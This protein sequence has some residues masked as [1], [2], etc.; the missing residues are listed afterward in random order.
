MPAKPRGDT[1]CRPPTEFPGVE[2]AVEK[3][4]EFLNF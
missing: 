2:P 4:F 3:K 1:I